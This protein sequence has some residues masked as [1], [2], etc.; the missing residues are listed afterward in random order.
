MSE[1]KD[2]TINVLI[3]STFIKPLVAQCN[4]KARLTIGLKG[5]ETGNVAWKKSQKGSPENTVCWQAKKGIMG[6]G[7]GKD[8]VCLSRHN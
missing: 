3:F 6:V 4:K 7:K 5:V 8:G 2:K 1:V